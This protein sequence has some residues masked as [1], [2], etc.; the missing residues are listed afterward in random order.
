MGQCYNSSSA[1]I[2]Q[3]LKK[4]VQLISKLL[5]TFFIMAEN[6]IVKEAVAT[7][8]KVSKEHCL[9]EE[10]DT[11][12]KRKELQEAAENMAREEVSKKSAFE[13]VHTSQSDANLHKLVSQS[14]AQ[15]ASSEQL[16]MIKTGLQIP[17]Y[18]LNF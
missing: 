17:S 10:F 5:H 6:P 9:L 4:P 7:A 13:F 18:R 12:R 16:Q 15:H 3:T 8:L 14:L 2:L 1:A 11:E